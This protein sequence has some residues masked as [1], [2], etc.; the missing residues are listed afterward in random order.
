VV[1]NCWIPQPNFLNY[2]TYIGSNVRISVNELKRVWKQAMV[3]HIG[4]IY[5]QSPGEIEGSQMKPQYS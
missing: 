3:V 1:M 2:T 5:W 4:A